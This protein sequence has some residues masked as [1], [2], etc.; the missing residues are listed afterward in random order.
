[1]SRG[2]K[3]LLRAMQCSGKSSGQALS[4]LGHRPW[5]VKPFL[6][7]CVVRHAVRDS[8]RAPDHHD[9][10]SAR[11]H[12]WRLHPHARQAHVCAMFCSN[13]NISS[14]AWISLKQ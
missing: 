11:M 12:I 7:A 1:M 8:G 4:R 10:L 6:H 2:S 3:L 13:V 14:S 5:S 9:R